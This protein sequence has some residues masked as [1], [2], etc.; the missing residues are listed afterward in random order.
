VAAALAA[1]VVPITTAGDR[2]RGPGDKSRFVKEIEDALL[3]GEVDVAVH[4][5]KDVPGEL[6]AGLEVAAVPPAEDARDALVGAPAL[7]ALPAGAVVGTSS[8]RRRSQLL[9]N[10]A[11][12][13]VTGLRGNVDTRLGKLAAGD[14]DAIVLALAGLRRLGREEAASP[15]EPR[16]FVPAP[17]QGALALE[18]RSG[19]ERTAAAVAQLDHQ[20]SHRRLDCE[21]TVVARLDASCHTPI[22]VSS[23]LAGGSL[24]AFAYVGLP[25]GSEWITDAVEGEAGDP[26]AVGELLAERLLSAGAG[27]LLRRAALAVPSA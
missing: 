15:L 24:H 26:V 25:D 13:E 3:A 4:S 5:A 17:G 23:E 1:E 12:L 19:D 6:P 9:A 21:R 27:E 10:R 18:V 7:D 16:R 11:D 20:P 8:L 14:Y 22:G 2:A